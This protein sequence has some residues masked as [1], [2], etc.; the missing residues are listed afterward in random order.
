MVTSL[1]SIGWSDPF[2]KAITIG[3][4][5][6]NVSRQKVRTY[7]KWLKTKNEKMDSNILEKS[8]M[9]YADSLYVSDRSPM[10]IYMPSNEVLF[11]LMRACIGCEKIEDLWIYD[12]NYTCS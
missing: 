12:N 6:P 9:A 3:K 10:C 1:N 2:P 5:I 8:G 4:D 11:K 7:N